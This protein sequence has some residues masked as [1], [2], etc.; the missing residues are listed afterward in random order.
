L[1][2]A[3]PT[4]QWLEYADWWN[5]IMAHP[6]ELRDGMAVPSTQPGSGVEWNETAIA[7]LAG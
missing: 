4:A 3:T 5:P 6:L 1:L 2:A 7:T